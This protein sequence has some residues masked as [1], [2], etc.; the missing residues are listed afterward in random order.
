MMLGERVNLVMALSIL[1]L[2]F[3]ALFF[4]LVFKHRILHTAIQKYKKKYSFHK[5]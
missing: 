4:S 1:E 5:E 2:Q 3:N